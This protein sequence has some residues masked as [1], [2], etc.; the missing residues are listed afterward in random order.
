MDLKTERAIETLA[1]LARY[2]ETA[3]NGRE[4]MEAAR[5]WRDII[6]SVN[7]EVNSTTL[8]M[9]MDRAS[10]L[11]LIAA[12]QGQ[13]PDPVTVAKVALSEIREW[14]EEYKQDYFDY[15]SGEL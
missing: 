13:S 6:H 14:G 8:D 10:D 11:W 12:L 7:P 2:P 3:S 15:L 1:R 9:T 4:K 5:A